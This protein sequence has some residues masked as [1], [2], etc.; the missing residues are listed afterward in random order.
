MVNSSVHPV[1]RTILIVWEHGGHLGH[2]G[3]LLPIAEALR[4]S[5]H[6]VVLAVPDLP[7]VAAIVD[8]AGFA[9]ELLPAG[10]FRMAQPKKSGSISHAEVL[11]HSGFADAQHAAL[12][13]RAWH[14][15]FD[16]VRPDAVLVD[17]SPLA[18][19][20]ARCAGV[21]A[22]VISHGFDLPP[23]G[24]KP[25]FAPWRAGVQQRMQASAEEL[26][27]A[28]AA[29]ASALKPALGNRVPQDLD[30]L[31]RPQD[32]LLC[33][34]PELDHF[35]RP[36]HRDG[37][38]AQYLGPVWGDLT[39]AARTGDWPVTDPITRRP[40]VLCYLYLHNANPY[41]LVLQS[42]VQQGADVLVVAPGASGPLCESM[43]TA[44]VQVIGQAVAL[45]P[46]IAECDAVV[47][48]G[49]AGTVSM[50]L[51]AGKPLLLLP[52]YLEHVVLAQS[53]WIRKLA[54]ATVRLRE[55]AIVTDHVAQLLTGPILRP[56]ALQFAARYT[57]YR[58]KTAV[59]AVV[60]RLVG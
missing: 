44:N 46:L 53:L 27:A 48:H 58:P 5:G 30:D 41:A 54:A 10:V 42:L 39:N 12:A 51:H 40:K 25:C 28:F 45:E 56:G 32:G 14:S 47:C 37:G 8:G 17:A 21:R 59:Q 13:V 49:G 1:S 52:R 57:G 29:L 43:Q 60:R 34:W 33:T 18:H 4:A 22:Q 11:L 26:Q 2:L 7:A 35:D 16:R 6:K 3:R 20:A 15:L 24:T 23:H 50:A 36:E 55:A 31:F 9:L 19:Y 38:G